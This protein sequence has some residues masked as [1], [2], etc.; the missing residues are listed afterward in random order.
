MPVDANTP[1]FCED[2]LT[3]SLVAI[4]LTGVLKGFSFCGM[5]KCKKSLSLSKLTGS[6]FSTGSL[7]VKF[8]GKNPLNLL[9][10]P[11][12]TKSQRFS[13]VRLI[14]NPRYQKGAGGFL[15]YR[16]L[17]NIM[18]LGLV[19]QG[20]SPMSPEEK[21]KSMI[22]TINIDGCEY[23]VAPSY[24]FFVHKSNCKNHPGSSAV[25]TSYN[26]VTTLSYTLGSYGNIYTITS[27]R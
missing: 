22:E 19:F 23:I 4:L 15:F 7:K 11:G 1:F 5:L 12:Y 9:T 3:L 13:A 16:W 14:N 2:V 21:A 8:C 26:P 27:S 10:R 6:A 18:L 20:C 24:C 17:F 25:K